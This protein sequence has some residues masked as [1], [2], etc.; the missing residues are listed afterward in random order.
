[1]HRTPN[2][3]LSYT[4]RYSVGLGAYSHTVTLSQMF[5]WHKTN[6]SKV[7]HLADAGFGVLEF[8][9]AVW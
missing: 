6:S 3:T 4:A 7:D 5:E 9:W 1:M 2:H 8:L